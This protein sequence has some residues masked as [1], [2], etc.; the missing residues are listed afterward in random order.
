MSRKQTIFTAVPA[1]IPVTAT[2][3]SIGNG[4]Y[5]P[6]G[7]IYAPHEVLCAGVV[8]T[9]RGFVGSNSVRS[10]VVADKAHHRSASYYDEATDIVAP[11]PVTYL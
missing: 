4:N 3:K 2:T 5:Y 11:E 1:P 7:S 6:T 10:G 9:S 8:C